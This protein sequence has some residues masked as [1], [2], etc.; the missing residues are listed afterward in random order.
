[1]KREWPVVRRSVCLRAVATLPTSRGFGL[2]RSQRLPNSPHT[3]ANRQNTHTQRKK[4]IG[5]GGA[6]GRGKANHSLGCLRIKRGKGVTYT[7]IIIISHITLKLM[8]TKKQATKNKQGTFKKKEKGASCLI[9]T[10][11]N[12]KK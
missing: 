11:L 1:M 9:S 10:C 6:G 12:Q 3:Y 2:R 8:M 4:W 5:E 7:H